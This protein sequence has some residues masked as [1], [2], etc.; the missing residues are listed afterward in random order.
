MDSRITRHLP[1]WDNVGNTRQMIAARRI[2]TRLGELASE[3]G[4]HDSMDTTIVFV[5]SDARGSPNSLVTPTLTS[6]AQKSDR[7]RP[8]DTA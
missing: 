1:W 2:G 8:P 6:G 5:C 4:N 7:F 3:Q